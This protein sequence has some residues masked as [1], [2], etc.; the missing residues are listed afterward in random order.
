LL[1]SKGTIAPTPIISAIVDISE[2]SLTVT[3]PTTVSGANQ[4]ASDQAVLVV[5]DETQGVI[6]GKTG[7]GARSTGTAT[8]DLNYEMQ[9]VNTIDVYLAFVNEAGTLASDSVNVLASVQA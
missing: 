1:I 3:F 2:Q 7:C 5:I 6:L 8:M 9:L 4:S